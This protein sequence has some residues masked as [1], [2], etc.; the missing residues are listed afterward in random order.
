MA[1]ETRHI[2]GCVPTE[3]NPPVM[4]YCGGA[5]YVCRSC[6]TVYRYCKDCLDQIPKAPPSR[7]IQKTF[8]K[9]FN[10]N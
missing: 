8:C 4:M 1:S 7:Q 10:S 2:H 6:G 3:Q 9:H 5:D